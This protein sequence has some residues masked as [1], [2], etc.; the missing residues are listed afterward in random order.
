MYNYILLIARSKFK[1]KKNFLYDV[2]L[3]EGHIKLKKFDCYSE[4]ARTM[5]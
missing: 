3:Y 5:L 2:I 1:K 4:N